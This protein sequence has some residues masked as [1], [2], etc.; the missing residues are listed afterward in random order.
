MLKLGASRCSTQSQQVQEG[1]RR[2]KG[3]PELGEDAFRI[4]EGEICALMLAR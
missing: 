2:E 1:A 3:I 4:F